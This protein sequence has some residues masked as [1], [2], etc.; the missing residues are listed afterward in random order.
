[1]NRQLPDRL[2]SV[3][4]QMNS[5][6]GTI[7]EVPELALRDE[8]RSDLPAADDH[9]PRRSATALARTRQQRVSSKNALARGEL[10]GLLAVTFDAERSRIVRLNRHRPF[11]RPDLFVRGRGKST[12]CPPRDGLLI[13][14]IRSA[15]IRLS[16]M[17]WVTR[18]RSSPLPSRGRAAR[19]GD[20]GG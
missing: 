11:A 19:R 18:T 8:M 12:E 7:G 4:V 13:T 15:R 5:R 2:F 20:R 17:S 16:S 3:S 1:V 10:G 6:D 9:G 14:R